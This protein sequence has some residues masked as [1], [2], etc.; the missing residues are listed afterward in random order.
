LPNF[1]SQNPEK[2]VENMCPELKEGLCELASI[3]PERIACADKHYCNSNE[4]DRC[5]VYIA[6]FFLKAPKTFMELA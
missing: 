2:E 1:F 5:K 6:Q 3:E 4:W